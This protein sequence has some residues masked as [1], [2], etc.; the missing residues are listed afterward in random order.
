MTAEEPDQKPN[1]DELG[2]SEEPER[3]AKLEIGARGDNRAAATSN[4]G[5][6]ERNRESKRPSP[7]RGGGV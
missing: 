2:P 5:P 4:E 3:I 7:K 6:G 1:P